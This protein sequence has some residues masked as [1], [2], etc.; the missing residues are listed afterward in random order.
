ML[1]EDGISDKM[2]DFMN[3]QFNILNNFKGFGNPKGKIWFVGVEEAAD[4]NSNLDNIIK[5]YSKDFVPFRVN[6]IREDALKYGKNYTEVYDIMAK[7]IVELYPNTDWKTY[8]NEKLLT[9]DSK[10]FQMNLYPL[11]KKNTKIWPKFYQDTFGFKDQQEYISFFKESR[12]KFLNEF[13][14][15]E[16]PSFTICFG[17]TYRDDFKI[18]FDLQ[19]GIMSEFNIEY[20]PNERVIITPFF[21]NRNMGQERI[22]KI[23]EI[24]KSRIYF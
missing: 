13:R 20:F 1:K 4:F 9:A 14:I 17:I 11:G 19:E 21:N 22:N 7:I 8:R 6:S 16:K 3:N 24:I 18:A 2:A 12:F 10:E 5:V 15:T 23:T